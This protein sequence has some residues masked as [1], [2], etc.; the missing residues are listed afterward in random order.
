MC[1]MYG[2]MDVWFR[3]CG[4]RNACCRQCVVYGIY[5]VGVESGRVC[6]VWALRGMRGVGFVRCKGICGVGNE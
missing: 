2:V 3:K 5:G 4:E 1:V 6:L